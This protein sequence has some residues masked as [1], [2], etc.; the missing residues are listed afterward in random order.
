MTAGVARQIEAAGGVL[1]RPTP[2]GRGVEVALVH[3]PKYDDWS[4]P[5]GKLTPGEHPLVGALREVEEETGFTA[6]AGRPLPQVRYLKDGVP[7]RVRYWA[8]QATGGE[9]TPTDEV[10]QV[11]WLPPK[12]AMVH[13]AADRDR[14]VLA[15]FVGTPL[16][17]RSMVLVRHGSAGERAAWPG[18]DRERP[19]DE[20]GHRQADALVEVL[21][22]FA[23]ER[24]ISADVQ[25]C[26]D[27]VAPYAAAGRITVESEPLLSES[28]YAAHS[29]AALGRFLELLAD[30]RPTVAC[31]Q[32]HTIPD[33]LTRTAKALGAEVPSDT[34]VRKGGFWVL[35][36][37]DGASEGRSGG[38]LR[39]V[40]AER[41]D[42]PATA[43]PVAAP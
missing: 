40:C 32:G 24:V 25:R 29:D 37:H 6:V 13:L 4:V 7:K 18:V 43:V 30:P 17:T 41:F 28:G 14:P 26:L 11:M 38:A 22:A 16:P 31:S 19:L 34:S 2:W 1:W 42:P 15:R 35:H 3:R 12:E 5:K 36:L 39:L 10:D 9:F 27:T 8:L 20:L 33:L 23:P 21:E